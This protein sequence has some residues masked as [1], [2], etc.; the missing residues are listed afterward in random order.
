MIDF[1]TFRIQYAQII[2]LTQGHGLDDNDVD[3]RIAKPSGEGIADVYTALRLNDSCIGRGF[4]KNGNCSGNGNPCT[5]CSGVRD[6]DYMKRQNK[7]PSTYTWSKQT[8]GT[9][10]KQLFR[11]LVLL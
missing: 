3:G 2:S 4:Y 7:S 10:G 11:T 5:S 8:C 6:I 1:P 9:S